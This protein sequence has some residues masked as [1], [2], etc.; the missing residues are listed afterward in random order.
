MPMGD[1]SFLGCFGDLV[2]KTEADEHGFGDVH[3]SLRVYEGY[4]VLVGIEDEE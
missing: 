2:G 1:N 3:A 4:C